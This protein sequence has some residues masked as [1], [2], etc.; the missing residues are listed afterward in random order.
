MCCTS[1]QFWFQEPCSLRVWN[2]ALLWNGTGVDQWATYGCGLIK[3]MCMNATWSR[4]H[5]HWSMSHLTCLPVHFCMPHRYCYKTVDFRQWNIQDDKNFGSL[6]LTILGLKIS[7][8][9]V[10]TTPAA[11]RQQQREQFSRPWHESQSNELYWWGE[12][13][14]ISHAHCIC[15]PLPFNSQTWNRTRPATDYSV[16]L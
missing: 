7:I 14:N 8:G 1:L 12:N 10:R 3:A 5:N 6:S 13:L 15:L 16:T 4:M 11:R 2:V 9:L